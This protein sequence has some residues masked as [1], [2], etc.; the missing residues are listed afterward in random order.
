MA[1][2]F[3]L[4][5]SPDGSNSRTCMLINGRLPGPTIVANWGDT[6]RI[7]VYVKETQYFLDAY[8]NCV[9]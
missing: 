7:T 6:L 1:A 9:L 5:C 2:D 8:A 4:A 3:C